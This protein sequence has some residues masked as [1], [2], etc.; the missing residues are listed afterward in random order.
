MESDRIPSHFLVRVTDLHAAVADFQA[1]G[2]TVVWGQIPDEAH[3]ALIHFP[4]GPFLELFTPL[5]HGWKRHLFR[6]LARVGSL[7]GQADLRRYQRWIDARGFCEWAIETENP[8]AEEI[9]RIEETGTE[10]GGPRKIVRTP[11]DGPLLKWSIASPKDTD[12]PFIMDPYRPGPHLPP[13]A[14]EH[15][16]GVTRLCALELT[17]PDPAGHAASLRTYLGQGEV[18]ADGDTTVLEVNGFEIRISRGANHSPAALR[19]TGP[20]ESLEVRL[21]GLTLTTE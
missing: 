8:L 1:A 11:P 5:P 2:F 20:D 13:G 17:D 10:M 21:H 15:A 18:T 4:E 3:N 19:G 16:N 14:T 7:V 12:L 9:P 6:V